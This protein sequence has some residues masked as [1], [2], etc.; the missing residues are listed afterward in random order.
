MGTYLIPSN[1]PAKL[2]FLQNFNSKLPDVATRYG[3]TA[4]EIADVAKITADFA[5]RLS[6]IEQ[7]STYSAAWTRFK[8]DLRDGIV[9]GGESLEPTALDLGT[10]PVYAD[11][12]AFKRIAGYV[13]RIK[14]HASYSVADG[15]NLGIETPNAPETSP[16]ELKPSL[17]LKVGNLGK[18]QILWEK[19]KAE[20]VSIYK[21]SGAGF[22]F[23]D[24]DNHPNYDDKAPLPAE[25]VTWRYKFIYRI[26]GE[27]VGQFSDVLTAHV[28]Q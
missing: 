26:G 16:A 5:Y 2:A 10:A 27:E 20:G 22:Q 13:Q 25:A 19:G 12:G 23:Y 17:K 24:I 7:I 9:A 15:A 28:G 18:P 14:T 1:D 11:P 8:N 21:D 4:P 3:I 6:V